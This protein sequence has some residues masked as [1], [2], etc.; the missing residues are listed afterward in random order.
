MLQAI[1][2]FLA[3]A[4]QQPARMMETEEHKRHQEQLEAML[5]GADEEGGPPGDEEGSLQ[6]EAPARPP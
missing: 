5:L 2:S 6:G 3:G 1:G 4:P